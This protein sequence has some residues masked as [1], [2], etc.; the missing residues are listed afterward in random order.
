MHKKMRLVLSL[1]VG[2]AI[3][4]L[5][6]WKFARFWCE[7]PRVRW[8][9]EALARLHRPTAGTNAVPLEIESI[10]ASMAKESQVQDWTSDHVMLFGNGDYIEYEYRHGANDLFPPHLLLAHTS[11]GQWIYSSFHFCNAMAM[12]RWDRQP[13]NLTEFMS[14]YSVLPFDGKSDECLKLTH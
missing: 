2:V 10:K 6:G 3:L 7:I 8:K 4:A 14:R 13:T 9:S 1:V 5:L 12:V 11:D